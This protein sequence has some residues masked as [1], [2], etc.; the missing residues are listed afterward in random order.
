MAGAVAVAIMLVSPGIVGATLIPVNTTEDVLDEKPGTCSLREALNAVQGDGGGGTSICPTASGIDTIALPAGTYKIT[1]PPGLGGANA[2]GSFG[3]CSSAYTGPLEVTIQPAKPGDKVVIDG[4]G[5]DRVFHLFGRGIVLRNLT[6]TGGAPDAGEF[7]GGAGGAIHSR[8]PKFVHDTDGLT[9]DGVTITGNN[10]PASGGA[11]AVAGYFYQ[12]ERP[13]LLTVLNSTISGNSAAGAG[14]GIYVHDEDGT[15]SVITVRSSTITDNVADS[16]ANGTGDGGGIADGVGATINFFNTINAGNKDLSPD[17]ADKAPDCASGPTF[18][19]RFVISGQALGPAPCLTGSDPGS[20]WVTD[21]K[22]GPLADNGGP[23]RTHALLAGSPA[24]DTAGTAAPDNCP[25]TDQRGLTRPAG[26]CDIGSFELGAGSGGG[27]G[28][29]PIKNPTDDTATFDGKNLHIRLKCAARFKPKCVSTAVPMSK[30]K[31]G[32]AMAKAKKATIKSN[33]WK[34]VSFLIKPAFRAAVQKMTT[35]N[36]KQLV[37]SQTV[38][39]KKVGKR[40]A[41]KPA[42]VFHVYKVRTKG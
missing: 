4:N 3:C 11:V 19:P 31:G 29:T 40:K 7:Y 12:V 1:K 5:I 38:K 26:K 16:D 21:P 8:S 14:G 27:G 20:N 37:V 10:S 28:L 9:L 24:I 35:V 13:S 33:K 2:N 23:T 42:R 36:R 39:S 17:P 22:L 6:I 15:P 32:K 18:F 41:K 30:K 25:V 34:R